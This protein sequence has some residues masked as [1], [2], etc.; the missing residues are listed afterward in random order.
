MGAAY[1][2]FGNG[3]TA[4]KVNVGQ[5]LQ[6]AYTGDAYTISNPGS[7]LVTSVNRS[8]S[9]PNGNRVAECDFMNPLASG[10]CGAWSALNW[11]SFA[12]ATT[13]NPD[14]L[15]GWGVRNRDWQYGVSV[16]QEIAPRVALEVSYNRRVWSNF[17]VTHNR[18]LTAAD[19]D[20]VTLTAPLNPLL[21]DGGGYPVTF[22]TRNTR[23]A[24]G[25]TDWYYTT[26]DDFGDETHYWHGVDLS[27]NARMRT[28]LVLQGG[29]STGRGVNDTCDS[30]IARFGRPMAPTLG[31]VDRRGHR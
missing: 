6:G 10:E 30:L 12:Q 4:L 7:T 15:K 27:F 26:T 22:L 1:D 18:A 16:Q 2:V 21:P 9:D 25:A 28:G 29:T 31:T 8:W 23:S 14:V 5:Y 20:T 17:F 24:L 13:V 19:Y 3:K 11:G